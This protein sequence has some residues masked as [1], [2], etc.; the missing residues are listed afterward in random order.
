M[1]QRL[2]AAWVSA[3]K[4]VGQQNPARAGNKENICR[5]KASCNNRGRAVQHVSAEH[6]QIEREQRAAFVEER[7]ANEQPKQYRVAWPEE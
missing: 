3:G 4:V 6:T 1:Q 7:K 5:I 2:Q